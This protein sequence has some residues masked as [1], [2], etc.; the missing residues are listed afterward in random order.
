MRGGISSACMTGKVCCHDGACCSCILTIER[1]AVTRHWLIQESMQSQD[2]FTCP[3][4]VRTRRQT[5]YWTPA[6][7]VY[8]ILVFTTVMGHVTAAA[9]PLDTPPDRNA[10]AADS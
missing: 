7:P 10:W 3:Y 1:H 5:L 6:V 4:K 9:M 8:S 2:P